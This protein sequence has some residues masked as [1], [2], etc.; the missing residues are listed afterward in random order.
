MYTE[1]NIK[2]RCGVLL[3]CVCVNSNELQNTFLRGRGMQDSNRMLK[4]C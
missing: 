4:D 2:L 1:R 3:W